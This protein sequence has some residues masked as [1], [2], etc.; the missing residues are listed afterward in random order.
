MPE[1]RKVC[2]VYQGYNYKKDKQTP[3]GFL[4][5]I[6]VGDKELA[7]DQTVKNPVT[8]TEDLKCVAVLS[9][10]LWETGVTDAV[11]LSGQLSV[12]NK[13]DVAL[14]AL[15][16]LTKVDVTYQF[17]V[18]A[19]DPVA[20]AYFKAFHSNDTDMNGIL[21]KRGEDLNISVSED[22]S[23]EVQ[24]PENYA[25]QVGIKP[26]PSAQAL[27]IATSSTKNVVKSWGLKV[28]S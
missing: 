5:K 6:K 11:Y 4:T 18:F 20:K 1:F 25:F 3:V 10:V 27:H 19:Y 2:D 13:Q 22:P 28:G 12:I 21:E 7:V 16:D 23:T 26:Q 15:T 24:S 14:L 17:T 9:D 8:P